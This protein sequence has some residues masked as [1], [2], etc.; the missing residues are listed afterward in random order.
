MQL[1]ALSL[2]LNAEVP[3]PWQRSL[4]TFFMSFG[5]LTLLLFD[6]E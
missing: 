6:F 5:A 1:Y 3:K 2:F 4:P